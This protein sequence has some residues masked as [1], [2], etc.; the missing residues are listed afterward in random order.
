MVLLVLGLAKGYA[1]DAA[2]VET[3]VFEHAKSPV[4]SK[5]LKVG[6]V[7]SGGGAKGLA[8]IGALKVIEASGV[9]IDYIAGTSMGVATQ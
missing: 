4:Q 3:V 2:N 5:E 7:L 8:H 6:L 9:Q 1:Q